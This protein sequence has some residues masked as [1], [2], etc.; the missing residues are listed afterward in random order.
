MRSIVCHDIYTINNISISDTL[1][2]IAVVCQLVAPKR[3]L[4][5][6]ISSVNENNFDHQSQLKV[7]TINAKSVGS[8]LSRRRITALCYSNAP[9]GVSVNV[10]ATGLDNGVIR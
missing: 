7:F 3:Q 4:T 10:I 6:P 8:V 2:D 1:G 9:E 5:L